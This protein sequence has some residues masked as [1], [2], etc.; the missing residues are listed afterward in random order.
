MPMR[1][2]VDS[3]REPPG[4]IEEREHARCLTNFC[5]EENIHQRLQPMPVSVGTDEAHGL[6]R[7]LD[8]RD[9]RIGELGLF[10]RDGERR[11]PYD[12]LLTGD[13]TRR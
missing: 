2:R 11:V 3:D 12:A 1:H 8:A 10:G 5:C 9:F 7:R 4:R 6:D 13:T